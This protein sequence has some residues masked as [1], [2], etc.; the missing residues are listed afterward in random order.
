[1][2]TLRRHWLI[3]TLIFVVFF[4][5]LLIFN[6]D[7]ADFWADEWRYRILIT[8]LEESAAKNDYTIAV[9]AIFRLN[10]R[11][12][13]GLFYYPAAF[14]EWRNPGIPFGLYYNL[15]INSLSLIMIYLILKKIRNKEAG[16]A[17]TLVMAF[18]IA[19]VI[20]I[21]HL[22]PYDIVLL[23]LLTGFYIYIRSRKEFLFGLLAGFSFLTY[24]SYY[25]YLLPIPLVLSWYH[26]S[27]RPALLFAAGAG[28]V[29]LFFNWFSLFAGETTSYFQSLKDES[30]GVTAI[31]H[32]DYMPAVSFI[33]EYI[34]SVDGFWGLLL[35]LIIVPGIFLIRKEKKLMVFV[36]YLILVFLIMETF[37]HILQKHVLYGRTIRPFYFLSLG[38][39]VLILERVFDNFRS[40][41]I[42]I[43]GL[44]IFVL[45][46]FLNWLPKY[47]VYRGLLYPVKF[48]KQARQYLDAKYGKY[49]IGDALFVNYWDEEAP[50]ADFFKPPRSN[51]FKPGESGKF[52]TMDAVQTFPYYGNYNLD[53][54][55]SN[56][57]LLKE[58]HIQYIFRPYL[59]EGHNKL[60][61]DRMDKDPLYYQLIYCK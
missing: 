5:R 14:L 22:L 30:E 18:S 7:A 60:M 34:L 37:S 6:K 61:R 43:F 42:Y 4:T 12:G 1:M 48:Q 53:L 56:E 26:R 32:G 27:I 59:F 38:L 45:I 17:A 20:Y 40:R 55:C 19:S 8:K 57:I 36:V 47:L 9:K 10:G 50:T 35:I 51:F 16:A 3:I 33:G 2:K 58:K 44:G 24:P 15:V 11:P 29:L 39:S 25:Y 52:Y 13:L 41:K 23:L 21:R 54:F 46:T 49:D 31:Y 28:A